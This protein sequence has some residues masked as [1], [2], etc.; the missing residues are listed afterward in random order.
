M[1]IGKTEI[2]IGIGGIL[3]GALAYKYLY[4]GKMVTTTAPSPAPDAT[5][6]TDGSEEAPADENANF[7]GFGKRKGQIQAISQPAATSKVKKAYLQSLKMGI[8]PA[9]A[10]KEIATKIRRSKASKKEKMMALS[11][12]RDASTKVVGNNFDGGLEI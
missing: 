1:N 9:Y 2:F 6:P 10:T 4:S 8:S 5:E 12:L 7:L 3:V 11:A